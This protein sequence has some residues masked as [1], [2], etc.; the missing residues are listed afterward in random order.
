MS[1]TSEMKLCQE[2]E[3]FLRSSG[4]EVPAH[5]FALLPYTDSQALCV[6]DALLNKIFAAACPTEAAINPTSKS[7]GSNRFGDQG[8]EITLFLDTKIIRVLDSPA[9]ECG[10]PFLTQDEHRNL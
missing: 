9:D 5:A 7:Q 3:I 4:D 10:G 8:V 6:A 2:P 1:L